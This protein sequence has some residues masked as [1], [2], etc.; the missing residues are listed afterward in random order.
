MQKQ[1]SKLSFAPRPP[2]A[3][4]MMQ[5][6]RAR[7]WFWATT[8]L[9]GLGSAAAYRAYLAIQPACGAPG[10]TTLGQSNKYV[11]WA[12]FLAQIVL[13][14]AVGRLLRQRTNILAAGVLLASVLAI[15]A[16][17]L[18][19]LFWFGAGDCGD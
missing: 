7:S 15:T 14:T 1:A 11:P 4:P 18:A 13:V 9:G 2:I 8:T 19:F 6:P 17:I 12:L 3:K 16:G 10:D 5:H